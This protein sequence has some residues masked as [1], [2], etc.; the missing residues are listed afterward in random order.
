VLLHL[1]MVRQSLGDY[2]TAAE[3][4]REA[5]GIRERLAA[6]PDF[7]VAKLLAALSGSLDL[8]GRDEEAL[9]LLRQAL[10]IAEETAGADHPETASMRNNLGIRL[11]EFGDLEEASGHYRRALAVQEA[12][13]GAG[14]IGTADANNNLGNVLMEI[15]DFEGARPHVERAAEINR[16]HLEATNFGRIASE[17]NLAT[18]RF[19]EGVLDQAAGLYGRALGH[20]ESLVGERHPA[21]ARVGALLARCLHLAGDLEEAESQ[22]RRS[23]RDQRQSA[24]PMKIEDTLLGLAALWSDTGRA[25][26]AEPL[27]REALELRLAQRRPVPWRLA[28]ARLE[29]G[30]ALLRQGRTGE[31]EELIRAGNAV[32]AEALPAGNF[33]RQRSQRL[34]DELVAAQ[35]AM[36]VAGL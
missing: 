8:S 10:Q 1:G 33:R 18:L 29:L 7:E 31:A 2:A 13:L 3:R 35:D 16:Q 27:A 11:H 26:E 4:F 24:D 15:G 17:I 34:L 5:L 9:E 6:G 12:R 23:L 14:A 28:E 32:L 22:F 20:F 30:G 25:V 36:R 19:E 21:T